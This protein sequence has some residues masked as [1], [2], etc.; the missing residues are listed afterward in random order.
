MERA[1][2]LRAQAARRRPGQEWRKGR[3]DVPGQRAPVDLDRRD[4]PGPEAALEQVA[5]GALDGAPAPGRPGQRV[6]DD[7]EP[8]RRKP[9]GPRR[10]EPGGVAP[11]AGPAAPSFACGPDTTAVRR[12]ASSTS[13]RASGPRYASTG[14]AKPL[15]SEACSTQ[16]PGRS[17]P[18]HAQ[19]GDPRHRPGLDRER[20]RRP[21]R[22]APAGRRGSGPRAPRR[23]RRC[24]RAAR[25]SRSR[26]SPAGSSPGPRGRA[27]GSPRRSG[28]GGAAR[29][30]ARRRG[31]PAG[32]A[33]GGAR[34]RGSPAGAARTG[35][36]RRSGPI[37]AARNGDRHRSGS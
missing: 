13:C 35:A 22:P 2:E 31:G 30:G 11:G 33:R 19:P 5:G 12:P 34:R 15:V 27:G 21:M 1:E 9:P 20:R 36:R 24:R 25:P 26:S 37:G 8:R 28:R 4:E 16:A 23:P 29:G 3:A 17:S 6:V 18:V 14:A 10:V 7:L 32:A